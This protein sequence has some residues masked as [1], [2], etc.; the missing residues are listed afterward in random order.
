MW[1]VDGCA[2]GEMENS[3]SRKDFLVLRL[4][5][6]FLVLR[7]VQVDVGD[8]RFR[9]RVC[10]GAKDVNRS[11]SRPGTAGPFFAIVGGKHEDEILGRRLRVK[12][13]TA[14]PDWSN[15]SVGGAMISE[16]CEPPFGRPLESESRNRS[17]TLCYSMM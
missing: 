5:K 6:D 13:P 17:R 12:C 4:V 10:V 1:S 16:P 15:Q 14:T 2:P 3:P 8:D 7:L 11:R 9:A